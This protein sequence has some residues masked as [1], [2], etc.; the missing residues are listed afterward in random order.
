MPLLALSIEA[1][2]V[3]VETAAAAAAARARSSVSG[4]GVQLAASFG[5]LSR[6]EHDATNKGITHEV[7]KETQSVNNTGLI[8]L[9]NNTKGN[10]ISFT[11]GND[12]F[13]DAARL[14]YVIAKLD[15]QV[16]FLPHPS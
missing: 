14:A 5:T 4:R 8:G 2:C 11:S 16:C 9:D 12:A 1:S 10:H 7:A 13:S 3:E 6:A 15:T